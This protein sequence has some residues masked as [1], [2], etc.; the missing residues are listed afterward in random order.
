MRTW[1]FYT[2]RWSVGNGQLL[3]TRDAKMPL[4]TILTAH[5][6]PLMGTSGRSMVRQ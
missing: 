4:Q 6:S 1:L 5:L 2:W 3:G